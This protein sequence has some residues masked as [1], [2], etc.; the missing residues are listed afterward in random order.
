MNS[1]I[2]TLSNIKLRNM[3]LITKLTFFNILVADIP[4]PSIRS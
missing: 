4:E 2:R 1:N 3:K